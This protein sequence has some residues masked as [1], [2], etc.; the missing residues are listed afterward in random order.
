MTGHRKPEPKVERGWLTVAEAAEELGVS[1]ATLYNLILADRF[2]AV[3]VGR[4]VLIPRRALD[5]IADAAI[6][7]RRLVDVREWAMVR[8]EPA[9]SGDKPPPEGHVE[10]RR[11][12]I[13]P[14]R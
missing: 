8:R 11:G 14:P 4:R 7:E 12:P 2:P 9:E 13:V 1:S 10:H 3:K 6:V 5:E